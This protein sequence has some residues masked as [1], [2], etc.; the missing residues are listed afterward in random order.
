M[1]ANNKDYL[2]VIERKII[3]ELRIFF[4]THNSSA[5]DGVVKV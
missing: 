2:N 3:D 1:V 5:N 4:N